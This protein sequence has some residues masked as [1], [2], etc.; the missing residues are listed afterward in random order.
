[1]RV[2]LALADD[3]RE[4]AIAAA[5]PVCNS[6]KDGPQRGLLDARKLCGA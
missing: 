2:A 4:E 5:R 6:M 1:L 3:R